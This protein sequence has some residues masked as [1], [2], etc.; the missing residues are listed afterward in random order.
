MS[1]LMQTRRSYADSSETMEIRKVVAKK[2]FEMP[3]TNSS[4]LLGVDFDDNLELQN[5]KHRC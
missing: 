3:A 4:R 1:K 5:G 2:G